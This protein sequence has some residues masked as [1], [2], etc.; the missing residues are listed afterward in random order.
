MTW[1]FD[2]AEAPPDLKLWSPYLE[3]S[4]NNW[5]NCF[6]DYVSCSSVRPCEVGMR[7]F[8]DEVNLRMR[9]NSESTGS[10]SA[11]ALRYLSAMA[12]GQVELDV[13]AMTT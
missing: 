11:S 1:A 10:P 13:L 12:T 2:A 7:P 3:T 9:G 5:F 8:V 4:E 6:E